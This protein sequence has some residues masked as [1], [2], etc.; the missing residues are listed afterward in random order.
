[1]PNPV[2]YA[3]ADLH[4]WLPDV[5]SDAELVIL[6]G[7]ICPDFSPRGAR[8]QGHYVDPSGIQQKEWL[9]TTFRVWL[10]RT[11]E[12]WL[13]EERDHPVKF[14]GVWGNHDFVGE[15]PFLI[16]EGLRWTLLQDQEF[17]FRYMPVGGSEQ[18]DVKGLRVWGTPWV[19]GLPYWAFF[20]D[21]VKL[22]EKVA[23]IPE[24]IDILISH[25]PPKGVLDRVGLR[26][27]GSEALLDLTK[28]PRAPQVVI[29]GH[30]HEG[31]GLAGS[32]Y[33]DVYNVAARNGLYELH[34]APFV[35]IRINGKGYDD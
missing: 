26:S 24:G 3:V 29:C 11:R 12:E 17:E 33:A 7:D 14:I 15:K 8:Y 9:N 28:T 34:K 10:E 19:P 1:M 13:R 27:T 32:G 25:G 31:R 4:G 35:R 21:D 22:S 16:P 18:T 23:L 20:A 6:A 5:P 30:I 2:I